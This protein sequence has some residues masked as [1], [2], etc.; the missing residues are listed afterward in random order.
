MHFH[1]GGGTGQQAAD[2]TGFNTYADTDGFIAVY[3]DGIQNSWNDGRGTT[4][5]DLLGI[6]DIGFTSAL[7]DHLAATFSIDA[8]R[9][10]IS[11]MSNGAIF[12]HRLACALPNTFAAFGPD[13]GTLAESLDSSCNVTGAMSR[14]AIHGVA[15]PLNPFLGGETRGGSGGRI[16]SEQ[17]TTEKWATLNGCSL[18]PS[19][20]L[21]PV[22]VNDG[23]SVEQWV[24]P[25]CKN[26]TDVI[27]Y[28][29]NGMGHAWP[30]Q[31]SEF[32][33]I[34]GETSQNIDATKVIWEFFKAHG[35]PLPGDLD[36]NGKRDLADVRPLIYMLLGQ[37]ATTPEADLTGDGAVTLADCQALIKLIV[38]IP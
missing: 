36:G 18:T 8:N 25:N 16:L 38:G 20:T 33:L 10:Y 37:Q 35:A 15:D 32:P 22:T 24:Y 19:K 30:P 6:D 28:A 34:G 2:K 13:A 21:L 14:V 27:L 12:T 9:I 11:G 7:I 26:G 3:P 5:A 29:V 1:G 23:T 31:D 17:A 4:V